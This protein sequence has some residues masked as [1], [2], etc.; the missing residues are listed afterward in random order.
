MHMRAGKTI[1]VMLMFFFTADEFF[2]KVI[3]RQFFARFGDN[4]RVF[5]EAVF[6]IIRVFA[7]D[8][9]GNLCAFDCFPLRCNCRISSRH[10]CG[11]FFIPAFERIAR[12]C[13]FANADFRT[14]FGINRFDAVAAVQREV[15]EIIL[16]VVV[17]F[18]NG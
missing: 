17:D 12:F 4:F 6:F 18:D 13:G 7:P 8:N 2:L 15:H 9:N 3:N 10:G 1:L 16:T 5:I 11:D 14:I